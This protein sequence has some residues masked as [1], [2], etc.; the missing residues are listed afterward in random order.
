MM[1]LMCD[2]VIDVV[3]CNYGIIKVCCNIVKLN[4]KD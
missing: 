3:C 2:A 1:L 4:Y